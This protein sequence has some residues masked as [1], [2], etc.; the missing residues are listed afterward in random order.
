MSLLRSEQS[1]ATQN[2][3]DYQRQLVERTQ[4]AKLTCVNVQRQ[5]GFIAASQPWLIAMADASEIMSVPAIT[6]VPRTRDWFAGLINYRGKLVS[7]IDF[8]CFLGQKSPSVLATDRLIV[9]S[10]RFSMPCALRVS[11]VHGLLETPVSAAQ[12]ATPGQEKWIGAGW[13]HDQRH[14]RE[15]NVA[16][17]LSDPKFVIAQST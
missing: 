3:R 13:L 10:E 14:W 4:S 9:L 6:V 2:L 12:P 11:A 1:G 5:L 7:V 16:L 17:L 8:E 15:L